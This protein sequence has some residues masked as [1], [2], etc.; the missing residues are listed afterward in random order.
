MGGLGLGGL[1]RFTGSIPVPSI[2]GI[3]GTQHNAT[4]TKPIQ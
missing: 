3:S 2:Q 4:I 1:R